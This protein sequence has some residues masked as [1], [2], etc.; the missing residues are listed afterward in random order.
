MM[1][2]HGP[3]M[4]SRISE[5]GFTLIEMMVAISLGLVILAGITTVFSSMSKTSNA[6]SSRTQRMSDLYLVSQIMQADLRESAADSSPS[7]S[8]PADLESGGRKPAALCASPNNKSVSLPTNYPTSFSSYPF[9]D[10]TSK[11]LTYQDQDGNTG[12]FYYQKTSNDRIYWLRPDPCIYLFAE[13]TREMDTTSGLTVTQP[14]SP[15]GIWTVTL[16]AV[17]TNKE[18]A[19]V[20]LTQSFKTRPRN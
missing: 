15:S 6:L 11:T 10:A 7:P 3:D 2:R 19:G 5:R 13:L 1:E 17:Y 20:I 18:N 8:F 12:I 4:G 16:N 14:A 9:W